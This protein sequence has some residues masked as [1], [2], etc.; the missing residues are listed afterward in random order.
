M[1][2]EAVIF[3]AD[4]AGYTAMMEMDE[5]GAFARVAA[6]IEVLSN[7]VAK[8]D[9]A[10]FNIAGDG[11][12]ASFASA[13]SA[14]RA[15]LQAQDSMVKANSSQPN[16]QGLLFR[17]GLHMGEVVIHDSKVF[18]SVVNVAA[19]LQHMAKPGDIIVSGPVHEAVRETS[20]CRF[21]FLGALEVRGVSQ[22]VRCFRVLEEKYERKS[23][24]PSL[25][26]KPSIAVLP[27][28]NFSA[29]P[30][31]EFFADGIVEDIINA[32]SRIH[33]LFVIGR[34]SSFT[35][36]NRNI[37]PYRIGE[38]LGVR[39]L[40]NGTVRR[41]GGRMRITGSL[42]RAEDGAQIWSNQFEGDVSDIF[43][44]QDRVT[45]GVAAIIE[46]RLLFAEVERVSREPPQSIAAH[47]LFLRATG[48]YYRLTQNDAEI[49]KD[50][51]D[52]ALRLDPDNARCLALGGRCRFFRKVQGWVRPDDPSIAEGAKMARR[53][54]ELAPND[55]EVLWTAGLVI[56]LAGGD[57]S[58]GIALIDRALTIN[59]NS[60]DALTYSGMA[61]AFQGDSDVALAH[62][63]RAQRLSP[64]DAQTY[65]KLTAAA[66]ATFTAER[67]QESLDWANRTLLEKP[68][69][70]PGWRIR[71]AC[72]GLLD[73]IDEG[74]A[75]VSRLL[76]LSPK[77]TQTSTRI[78][79]SGS[80][81]KAS[82][83]DA[84]VAGL[85]RAGLPLDG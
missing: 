64:R 15:A 46:P 79:F 29:D 27:F 22:R 13:P 82:A 53:A 23:A 72:L 11:L 26:E 25:P 19:R 9:G 40:L 4:I 70:L 30:E 81:L 49:A 66:L 58:G 73:R 67:Y 38:E 34:G 83:V 18:G 3:A 57:S 47:D 2:Q 20:N 16:D 45:E 41:A 14:L 77:E 80:K 59:P 54:A 5:E 85:G 35:Y 63:E 37:P 44:L 55:A 50:L 69:Y 68:D 28:A 48:H 8:E 52:R 75:A 71:T 24:F 43:A 17:M 51:T 65:N 31:Q 84:F 6:A 36:K 74:R 10:V 12:L 62:L 32:L 61:R 39:Y 33:F 1:R 60:S 76:A 7:I 56:A 42:I 78:Y 21:E